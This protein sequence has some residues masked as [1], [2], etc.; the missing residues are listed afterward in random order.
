MALGI[1]FSDS[2]AD[3]VFVLNDN[4]PQEDRVFKAEITVP[5]NRSIPPE[6]TLEYQPYRKGELYKEANFL[7][8]H[9]KSFKTIAKVTLV[10]KIN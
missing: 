6:W 9:Y 2:N 3:I 4:E 7:T 1:L 8:Y 10:L 5:R